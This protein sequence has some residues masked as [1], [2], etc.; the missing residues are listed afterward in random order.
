M[1]RKSADVVSNSL[2]DPEADP[3]R[4]PN[5]LGPVSLNDVLSAPADG[6][7]SL[8]AMQDEP[9]HLVAQVR[10]LAEVSA[11]AFELLNPGLRFLPL[12]GYDGLPLVEAPSL[13]TPAIS[14]D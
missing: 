3:M 2:G 11:C 10:K 4:P 7:A 12:L 6:E 8:A 1:A 9:L 14:E 13:I 5:V